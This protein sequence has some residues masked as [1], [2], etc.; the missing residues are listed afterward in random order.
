VRFVPGEWISTYYNW[1]D[2]IQDWCISRQLWWGHQIPAWYDDAGN[3]YVARDEAAARA[4]AAAALG[5]DPGALRREDDVLD[6]W[7]SSALWCHSTLGWPADT[8]ELRTFLPSS[9]LVTGFDII[10]FWV[11]RMIMTT[12]YFTGKVPFHDVYINAIVRDEEG[13]KMSKSKGNVLDPLDLIDGIDTE[14]LVAKR[15]ANMMDPRQA[16][17]IAKRTR[18]QFPNGIPAFGADAVR[19]TFASLATFNRT[20]NFDLNRCEGYRNF[21]NKLWN[22]ARFVLMN[23]DGRDVGLD[24]SL[25]LAPTFADKWIIAE[26]QDV[27]DEVR[28]QLDEY[29][30]D[31]A[32]RALYEFVWNEYCDWYLEL[33]KVSLAHGDEAQQRATRKTLVRVLEAALRLAHPFIP[34]ITEELWQTVR[35]LA[36]KNGDT[37]SLQPYP[38]P[39]MSLRAPTEST[40]VSYLKDLVD[41]ARSLRSEM[42]LS[43]GQKVGAFLEGD[44]S[45]IGAGALRPYIEALARL[46]SLKLVDKLPASPAPVAVV[47]KFRV[48]LEVEVDVEAERARLGKERSRVEGEVNKARAKLAN[49]GF[50]ARAPAAVVE[51]ERAR[52]SQF[53]ATLQKLE[54]QYRRLA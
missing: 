29:R 41:A 6:T 2:N 33:A 14:S 45:G 1:I 10:F 36:G 44:F 42:G 4:K 30:F 38:K 8:P 21:C 9:V 24:E 47:D 15:T 27:E 20:L 53:E 50:V 13:Q 49:E 46:S 3:V 37:I 17:S 5:R 25:P 26:L 40:Q 39:D 52:L 32:A 31:H 7:F 23:V 54:E 12:T 43:P 35:P 19:F 34:F 51:Q 18:K 28:T 11:A 48:M 22:A 16:D